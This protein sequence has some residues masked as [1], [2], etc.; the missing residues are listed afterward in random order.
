MIF[1]NE[2]TFHLSGKIN[3]RNVCILHN[4]SILNI[5]TR[6]IEDKRVLCFIPFKTLRTFFFAETTVTGRWMVSGNIGTMVVISSYGGFT[7]FHFLTEVVPRWMNAFLSNN[8][9]Q[10]S[11]P[12]HCYRALSNS[13][14]AFSCVGRVW[15]PR[16]YL[17]CIQTVDTLNIY[18]L[19]FETSSFHWYKEY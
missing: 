13:R 14:Y 8:S 9:E 7:G 15:L 5:A 4:G 3:R 16:R 2:A 19:Y 6:L 18:V 17:S 12:Y 11:E 10:F 1:S